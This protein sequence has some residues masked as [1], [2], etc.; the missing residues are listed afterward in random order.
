M[1][2]ENN[3]V[4]ILYAEG[5]YNKKRARKLITIFKQ[6]NF[7][8][9]DDITRALNDKDYFVYG[10]SGYELKSMLID[11]ALTTS[12]YHICTGFGHDAVE[13]LNETKDTI[14]FPD[15][16]CGSFIH[17]SANNE[18]YICLGFDSLLEK[19]YV[20][21]SVADNN[22]KMTIH[23]CNSIYYES[24]KWRFATDKE[25]EH[26]KTIVLMKTNG[27]Y[28]AE[29]YSFKQWKPEIGDTYYYISEEL[30]IEKATYVDNDNRSKS[31]NCF[32]CYE[33]A[34]D[35]LKHLIETKQ[36]KLN[37][38]SPCNYVKVDN[39]TSQS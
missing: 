11:Y 32:Y 14:K 21:V 35:F 23:Y 12:I 36:A 6:H 37:V 10:V 1:I 2:T 17:F 30:T 25:I 3:K 26:F 29:T 31:G 8:V 27:V 28:D 20:G 34:E 24:D 33:C 22:D 18:T 16:K 13:Q 15:Y 9:N 39:A 4:S 19:M 7:K 38:V 5:T